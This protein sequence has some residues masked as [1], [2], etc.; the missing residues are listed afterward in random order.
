MDEAEKE[1]PYLVQLNILVGD[2]QVR[3]TNASFL[4]SREAII[5]G[6]MSVKWLEG[7]AFL[8][9]R[10]QINST[11]PR[12]SVSVIS[13]DMQEK[14]YRVLYYD[15][16]GVSRNFD[17]SFHEGL[18]KMWRDASGEPFFQRFEGQMSPGANEIEALW[19]RSPDG[20][21]WEHDFDMTYTRR[22]ARI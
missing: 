8:I 3:I 2:W 11:V 15:E 10:S 14:E 19:E 22:F 18:W 1:N 4:P 20:R 5:D 12:V 6:W 16:R 9:M 21:I 13:R 17:M 7:G